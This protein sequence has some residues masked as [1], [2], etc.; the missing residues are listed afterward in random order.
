MLVSHNGSVQGSA[1]RKTGGVSA[2]AAAG[3]HPEAWHLHA[4]A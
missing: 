4:R 3:A 2:T 1:K